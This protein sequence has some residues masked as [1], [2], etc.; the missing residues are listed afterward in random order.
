M[1]LFQGRETPTLEELLLLFWKSHQ[2]NPQRREG[3][4]DSEE[5]MQG[6]F[7][8]P[9]TR[10]S[11]KDFCSFALVFEE[12]PSASGVAVQLRSKQGPYLLLPC[13]TD[14]DRIKQD[15]ILHYF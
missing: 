15:K 9:R 3:N 4:P 10:D 2:E 7:L 13:Q 6:Y 12:P 1:L 11:C 14:K 8:L 5:A